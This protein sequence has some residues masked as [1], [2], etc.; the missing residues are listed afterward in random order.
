MC[1]PKFC[2]INYSQKVDEYNRK[3]H[4]DE[5]EDYSELV[6]KQISIK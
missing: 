5:K 3:I 4:E 2:S 1:G 6:A